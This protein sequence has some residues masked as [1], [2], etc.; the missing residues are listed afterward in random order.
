[1]V[2]AGLFH[3][4][5]N[6]LVQLVLGIPL[7]MV[8]NAWRVA[9]VYLSG[10]LAGSLWT[11]LIKPEVFL[12][13]ASGGVYALITA[14]LGTV[15]MNHREMSHPWVRVGVVSMTAATDVC[16]YI[17]QTAVL[18]Q[19]KPVSYPAHIAGAASGLLV[20]WIQHHTIQYIAI[21]YNHN[22]CQVLTS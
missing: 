7:E 10:V 4:T 19:A 2:H 11:S 13:G 20:G 5:F 6:I 18:G 8:H 17:Y 1:M 9:V 22:Y 14:H 21:H 15:I 3:C 12:S 16:V